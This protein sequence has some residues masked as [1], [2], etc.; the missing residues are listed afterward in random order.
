M[1][2]QAVYKEDAVIIDYTAA[3]DKTAGAVEILGTDIIGVI[4]ADIDYSTNALGATYVKGV[5]EFDTSETT[6]V[7]GDN[8]YWSA[9]SEEIT[10]TDTD[11]YAGRVV[12]A[13][14]SS[15][16]RVSINFMPEKSGS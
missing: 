8:A 13:S 5:F 16:V 2:V 4:V 1:A 7:V 10:A 3:A 15:K 9:S 14:A 12:K 11:V 6:M